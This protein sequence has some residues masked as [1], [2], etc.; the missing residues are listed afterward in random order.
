MMTIPTERVV[1]YGEIPRDKVTLAGNCGVGKTTL[2][3]WFKTGKFVDVQKR[4]HYDGEFHKEWNAGEDR[5]TVSELY[6]IN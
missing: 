6:T 2:L 3:M 4:G 5:V 1:V